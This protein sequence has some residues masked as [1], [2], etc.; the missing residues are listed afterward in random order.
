MSFCRPATST[1]T[2]IVTATVAVRNSSSSLRRSWR[3]RNHV[4]I[5][6]LGGSVAIHPLGGT[7]SLLSF[8]MTSLLPSLFS[9][10]FANIPQHTPRMLCKSK[11]GPRHRPAD[12]LQDHGGGQGGPR[13]QDP[14]VPQDAHQQPRP[15]HGN[16]PVVQH[17]HKVSSTPSTGGGRLTVPNSS[18]FTAVVD[19][20]FFS[21]RSTNI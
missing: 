13:E 6:S 3:A 4:S 20:P 9:S 2:V 10:L 12:R 1:V 11:P 7:L 19:E 18:R 5:P 14:G 8:R 21:R 16:H 17:L 15:H